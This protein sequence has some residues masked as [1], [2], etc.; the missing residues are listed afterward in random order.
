MLPF[1]FTIKG[2]PVSLQSRKRAR[3]QAWKTDVRNAA[4]KVAKNPPT[5][6]EVAI[7]ITYYYDGDTPDVDNII[8]PIQ[9]ALIGVVYA[10]DNQVVDTRSRKSRIDGSFTI[11]G[12]SALLLSAFADGD[13]FLHVTVTKPS[14]HSNLAS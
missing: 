6:D 7:T 4:T 12:A 1:E 9:D 3:L 2:P 8:K 13:A 11:R 5:N 10:D 14:N